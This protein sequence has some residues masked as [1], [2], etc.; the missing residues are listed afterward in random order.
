MNRSRRSVAIA[1]ALTVATWVVA[2]EPTDVVVFRGSDANPGAGGGA[3]GSGG[4]TGGVATGGAPPLT[5]GVQ[6]SGGSGTGGGP[7]TCKS[8]EICGGTYTCNKPRCDAELGTCEQVPLF[9]DPKQFEPVCGCDGV[10]YWNDCLRLQHRVPSSTAGECG[11]AGL[12]CYGPADCG[13]PDATCALILPP[14]LPC[15]PPPPLGGAC[16][17]PPPT[18]APR[19]DD[20]RR[21]QRCPGPFPA[22]PQSSCLDLCQTLQFPGLYA[23]MP[24]G[25]CP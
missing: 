5:G 12:P 9:C 17:V 15:G 19:M 1:R 24:R 22:P 7:V 14:G 25:T 16:W 10:T 3:S 20:P 21:W 6:A 13:V 23:Q 2:C 11:G 18:C 8:S 4:A